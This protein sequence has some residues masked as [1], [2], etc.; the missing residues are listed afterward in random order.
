MRNYKF[1][2]TKTLLSYLADMKIKH[3]ILILCMGYCL[4]AIGGLFKITHHPQADTILIMSAALKV[5]GLLTF[6]YKLTRYPKI[7]EFL[8]S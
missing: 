5:L 3:A 6:L 7:K 8:N 1:R 4:D 2:I